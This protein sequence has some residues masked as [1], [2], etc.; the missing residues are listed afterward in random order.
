MKKALTVC[1]V[2]LAASF[3]FAGALQGSSQG[4][5]QSLKGSG[6][7]IANTST[8]VVNSLGVAV[9]WS[10]TAAAAG[11][12]KAADTS[13]FIVQHPSVASQEVGAGAMV[14]S[15]WVVTTT[16]HVLQW[17]GNTAV[18]TVRD[19]LGESGK[20][21]T[22]SE[23]G[24]RV[25]LAASGRVLVVTGASAKGSLVDT[26]NN[27]IQLV[28]TG[29]GQIYTA[30]A[31]SV[32]V[33]VHK[34]GA[35]AASAYNASKTGAKYVY[36]KLAS[37]ATSTSHASKTAA[38]SVYVKVIAIGTDSVRTSEAS[39]ASVST[40]VS[41][42]VTDLYKGSSDAFRAGRAAFDQYR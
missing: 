42:A 4:S 28:R 6:Q 39:G 12:M 29:S 34:V 37:A 2:T 15:K 27:P 13:V 41:R 30:S 14:A 36:G 21:L 9:A 24:A 32:V 38:K 16:G 31:G 20:A 11:S 7:M 10:S 26:Y 25:T 33:V 40:S 23:E 22:A 17:S 3:A 19:P 18:A 35:S 1:A 5:Y 8:F